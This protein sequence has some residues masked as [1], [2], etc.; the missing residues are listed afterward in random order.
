[1]HDC[2]GRALEQHD[3]FE[4]PAW[5]F[6]AFRLQQYSFGIA[7]ATQFYHMNYIVHTGA[8]KT[9]ALAEWQT[10]ICFLNQRPAMLLSINKSSNGCI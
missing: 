9:R 7:Q 3:R 4:F 5:A 10:G 1:M 6:F 8:V 2:Q